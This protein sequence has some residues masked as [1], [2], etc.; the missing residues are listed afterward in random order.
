MMKS[1]MNKHNW[2]SFKTARK[3][4]YQEATSYSFGSSSSCSIIHQQQQQQRNFHSDRMNSAPPT[5]KP[6]QANEFY[7]FSRD[8]AIASAKASNQIDSI[9]RVPNKQ[10]D[11]KKENAIRSYSQMMLALYLYHWLTT[12]GDKLKEPSIAKA[13]SLLDQVTPLQ[14]GTEQ[15]IQIRELMAREFANAF[16]ANDTEIERLKKISVDERQNIVRAGSLLIAYPFLKGQ[17]TRDFI[18][19]ANALNN[20][21]IIQA[22]DFELK[23]N[24]HNI[25]ESFKEA[26]DKVKRLSE[27]FMNDVFKQAQQA[28]LTQDSL[29]QEK[30][31]DAIYHYNY[32][33]MTILYQ[34]HILAQMTKLKKKDLA[35]MSRDD[36]SSFIEDASAAEFAI[37]ISGNP[38][39]KLL[40]AAVSNLNIHAV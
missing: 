37:A 24:P 8:F 18:Q 15:N 26:T 16:S 4:F 25:S 1:M 29:L 38:Y 28:S 35:N 34:K 9:F 31:R 19:E 22:S 12:G 27:F 21:Q 33:L 11:A 39:D 40:M 14:S 5:I 20:P 10:N 7:K 6:I 13:V 23:I 32:L 36:I 2:M 3:F 30:H 17:F